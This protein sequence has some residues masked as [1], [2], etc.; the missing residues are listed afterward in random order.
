MKTRFTKTSSG[1]YMVNGKS[2]ETLIGSRAQVMHG[3]AYKTTGGLKKE[4]IMMNKHGR[5]VSRKKHA[6]A[7]KEKR[8]VKA[9]FLTKKGHF[10]F[11]KSGSMHHRSRKHKGSKKMRGGYAL[12][13]S[14]YTNNMSVGGGNHVSNPHHGTSIHNG[15]RRRR[16]H[17]Y[18]GGATATAIAPPASPPAS[19]PPALSN[20]PPVSTPA[21]PA[22]P[23]A[24][25]SSI[26][27][28]LSSLQ[29]MVSSPP[30]KGGSRRR[31]KKH[32]Y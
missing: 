16:T 32:R 7:S 30:T 5:I 14:D 2:Y 27:N 28:V 29:N 17:R 20:P 6:T 11:I 15:G 23:A 25:A 31:H 4:G 26:S 12:N 13:P 9:G 22:P 10:G 18:R 3:T 8:L 21:L 24:S 1:K 19:P